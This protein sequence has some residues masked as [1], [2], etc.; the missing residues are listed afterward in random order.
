MSVAIN[1]DIKGLTRIMQAFERMAYFQKNSAFD[2]IGALL[3]SQTRDRI[4]HT[5]TDPLGKKWMP[6]SKGYAQTRSTGQ[7]LLH[8]S[9]GLLDSIHY[10]QTAHGVRVGSHRVYAALH[11]FGG[12]IAPKRTKALVFKMKGKTVFAKQ[13]RIPARPY[14]GLSDDNIKELKNAFITELHHHIRHA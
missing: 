2:T 9:G 5:K 7:S 11:Q 13:V 4:A 8:S 6:W 3:E 12:K 10:Q 1:M 14:L